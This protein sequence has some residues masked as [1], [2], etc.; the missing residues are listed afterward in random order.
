MLTC[1]LVSANID[2]RARGVAAHAHSQMTQPRAAFEI[3]HHFNRG[4]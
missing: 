4:V 1:W 3:Q 2:D